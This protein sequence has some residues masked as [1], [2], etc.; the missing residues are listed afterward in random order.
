[1]FIGSCQMLVAPVRRGLVG[2][3]SIGAFLL[4]VLSVRA[5]APSHYEPTIESLDKHPLPR[6]YADAKLG[7]FVHWGLY[8]VPGWA[9]TVHSEH[10]FES[11]D[12]I[13][14]NPYAEWYLNSMRLEG[15]PTHAYHREHYGADYD[16]YSFAPVFDRE[17]QK[18]HA[19][20]WA[21]VFRDAGAKYVVLTTKHHDGFTLW[22]SSTPNPSLPAD[23][24]HASRDL[25]GE[26][27]AAVNQQGLRM[28][29]YYSGGY[30]WTFV[31]GPIRVAADYQTVKPQSEAYGKYADAQVREL[32]AHYRPAVLWNDI[33]YPK[34]GHPLQ[35]MAEYYEAVPDG[36]IDDRFGVKHSDFISPE[37]QTLEK[38]N[39]KK[40]EECR[41][42]G[43]SF[44]YN[45]AE[46]EAETIK[47]DEL[48]DLLVD[49]VSK[50]G[51][52]LLDV[53]PEADGTI[54]EVQMDRLNALGAW[55]QVNG[56]A[57]YG[58]HPWKRANGETAEGI[59]IRFTQKDSATYAILLGQPKGPTVTFKSVSVKPG[60]KIYMLGHTEPLAW[61]QQGDNLRLDLPVALTGRYAYSFRIAGPLS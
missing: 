56:E 16:Y 10:D 31:P 45:R 52:L 19:E 30:D 33:D 58:T 60:T 41:G 23:R 9:P 15:S 49:I 51:N 12:Y 47:P 6:W 34:S 43:R 42:L 55:L 7:I 59:P 20:T 53:G 2:I 54:P 21:K 25:V 50:N 44:G 22:P 40:W 17:V 5:Q 18:W 14:H 1:M 29:L 38:I 28:G 57:I 26:L 11:S 8:S 61:S 35:I 4:A 13:T 27:T 32:I 37:Y 36:V 24:Q 3:L 39:P 48:I 46:G